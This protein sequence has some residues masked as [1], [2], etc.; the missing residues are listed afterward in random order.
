MITEGPWPTEHD[1]H[2]LL[3]ER[4]A[5]CISLFMPITHGAEAVKNAIRLKNLVRT[6]DDALATRGVTADERQ[7]LLAPIAALSER[8]SFWA[9]DQDGLA[10]FRSPTFD[11]VHRLPFVVTSHCVVDDRF[12]IKPLFAVAS[13]SARFYIVA[14]QLGHVRLFEAN[15]TTVREVDLDGIVPQNIDQVVSTDGTKQLQF[16]SVSGGVNHGRAGDP[17]YHGQGAGDETQDAKTHRFFRRVADALADVVV[18]GA[19]VV[20]IGPEHL[21]PIFRDASRKLDLVEGMVTKNPESLDH[22]TMLELAWPMVVSRVLADCLA[23]TRRA[24]ELE[25]T[26]LVSHNIEE[27]VI[28]ASDGRLD[29][30]FI[31]RD[32]ALWGRFDPQHRRVETFERRSADAADLYDVA[33]RHAFLT[34]TDIYLLDHHLLP[35]GA[36]LTGIFRYEARS[37]VPA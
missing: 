24:H 18:A 32:K 33:A 15:R 10:I 14:L 5:P 17:I 1:L 16:H 7:H 22:P 20:L 28:A 23:A 25:G 4:N 35:R 3:S 12:C 26:A 2:Q 19:P 11:T 37:R 21:V 30:L 6:A 27:V 13:A 34:G 8:Q 9:C 31:P 36:D 29:T